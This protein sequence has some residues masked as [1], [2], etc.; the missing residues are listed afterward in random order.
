MSV[1]L[2][3]VDVMEYCYAWTYYHGHKQKLL[4]GSVFSGSGIKVENLCAAMMKTPLKWGPRDWDTVPYFTTYHVTADF[5]E[6][7][8]AIMGLGY[9]SKDAYFF[10]AVF[11]T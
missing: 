3:T 6:S 8:N 4:H 5:M 2:L 11:M 9:N 1:C 7:E 10:D